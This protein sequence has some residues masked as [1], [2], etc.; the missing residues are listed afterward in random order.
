M[1]RS[2]KPWFYSVL[3]QEIMVVYLELNTVIP[4]VNHPQWS[5]VHC[6]LSGNNHVRLLHPQSTKEQ[7]KHDKQDI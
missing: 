3:G 6:I 1:Y 4:S 7:V 5:V 2:L